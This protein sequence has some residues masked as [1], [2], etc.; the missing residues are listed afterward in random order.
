M[1]TLYRI[2]VIL[3]VATLIGGLIYA[4]VGSG[5]STSGLPAPAD[6]QPRPED[7]ESPEGDSVLP[8]GVLKSLVIMSI[9]GGAYLAAGKAISRKKSL[10]PK[11]LIPNH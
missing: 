11:S 7:G 10:T 5:N 3:V 6:G 2:L 9:A 8:L 1:S 4:A